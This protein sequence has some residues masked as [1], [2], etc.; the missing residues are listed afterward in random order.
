MRLWSKGLGL[1]AWVVWGVATAAAALAV[2]DPVVSDVV[3]V[4]AV[5]GLVAW[6]L[7]QAHL[8][9]WRIGMGALLIAAVAIPVADL[10]RNPPCKGL[11]A[12]RIV[13]DAQGKVDVR[14]VQ[15]L[16]MSGLELFAGLGFAGIIALAV[17]L[18]V[19]RR[20]ASTTTASP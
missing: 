20:R 19:L 12:L 5:A 4:L 17:L 18:V 2:R 14:C 7:S 11:D 6:Y 8:P 9:S 3:V 15:H 16:D 10:V 1:L 13:H